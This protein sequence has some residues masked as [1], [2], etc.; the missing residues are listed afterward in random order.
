L[1]SRDARIRT[2]TQLWSLPHNV[3]CECSVIPL[4]EITNAVK[5]FLSMYHAYFFDAFSVTQRRDKRLHD[6]SI[7]KVFCPC[8][9][10]FADGKGAVFCGLCRYCIN[11][12][13]ISTTTTG[14]V[15]AVVGIMLVWFLAAHLL[16]VR[17]V[18]MSILCAASCSLTLSNAPIVKLTYILVW[19]R[20]VS[21]YY[22]RYV[23]T[24]S[25]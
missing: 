13:V 10:L 17:C 20:S 1:Q 24:Y 15:N 18:K 7:P 9:E 12:V 11:S 4:S 21:R 14:T 19:P 22:R 2:C 5:W 23:C 16:V 3:W 8:T 25:A 6:R